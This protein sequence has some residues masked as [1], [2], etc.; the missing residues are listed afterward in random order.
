METKTSEKTKDK[1]RTLTNRLVSSSRSGDILWKST[2]EEACFVTSISGKT[3]VFARSSQTDNFPYKY[4]I[5]INDSAGKLVDS[6]DDEDLDRD[7]FVSG[8][9]YFKILDDFMDELI[10]K[11]SGA[12]EVLDELLL[13]L[14]PTANEASDF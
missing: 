10:R 1:W 5:F 7:H 14:G 6:F 11:E 3:I 8:A 9:S 2:A 13:T 12:D 4:V